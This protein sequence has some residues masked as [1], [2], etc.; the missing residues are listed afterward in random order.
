MHR[1]PKHFTPCHP[2]P[3]PSPS[4]LPSPNGLVTGS[5]R[6]SHFLHMPELT[7]VLLSPMTDTLTPTPFQN[8]PACLHPACLLPIQLRSSEACLHR[9]CPHL[10]IPFRNR[11]ACLLPAC[12]VLETQPAASHPSYPP[13]ATST[14]RACH[15][16]PAQC[17]ALS[18]APAR[19]RS[20]R[21]MSQLLGW[22][23]GPLLR[24]WPACRQH[25]RSLQA[26][27]VCRI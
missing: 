16:P 21:T 5:L 19:S 22:D 7:T 13:I 17:P 3:R 14:A 12:T 18:R 8:R 6:L 26:P 15:G 1:S 11:A 2:E 4:C 20:S 23:M 27:A 24:A 10:P 9:E 25:H